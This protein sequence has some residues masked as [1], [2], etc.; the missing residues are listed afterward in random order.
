MKALIWIAFLGLGIWTISNWLK[1]ATYTAY[2]Y[3]SPTNLEISQQQ[4]GLESLDACRSW[5]NSQVA[6]DYDGNYDYE[7]GKNCTYR[8]GLSVAVCE[9]TER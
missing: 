9:T 3:P 1:P 8:E 7:C 5:I 2:F 4:G 6:I